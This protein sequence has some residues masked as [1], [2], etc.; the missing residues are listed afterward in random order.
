MAIGLQWHQ[1]VF[2]RAIY[3]SFG[4]TAVGNYLSAYTNASIIFSPVVAW[5]GSGVLLVL[6]F[7]AEIILRRHPLHWKSAEGR[8]TKIDRLHTKEHAALLGAF[9]LLWLPQVL[10]H[11]GDN[12]DLP[13]WRLVKQAHMLRDRADRFVNVSAIPRM[14]PRNAFPSI[15]VLILRLSEAKKAI[16]LLRGLQYYSKEEGNSHVGIDLPVLSKEMSDTEKQMSM[17]KQQLTTIGTSLANN[18]PSPTMVAS[19]GSEVDK[20][21]SQLAYVD[22]Q[23]LLSELSLTSLLSSYRDRFLVRHQVYPLSLY[24][25]VSLHNPRD[26]S[27]FMIGRRFT[28]AGTSFPTSNP[29]VTGGLKS[30]IDVSAVTFSV[31]SVIDAGIAGLRVTLKNAA[32]LRTGTYKADLLFDVEK[33]RIFPAVDRMRPLASLFSAPT[34]EMERLSVPIVIHVHE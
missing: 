32:S 30:L 5:T 3:A 7:S 29:T 12:G 33:K 18:D 10:V 22:K 21:S 15:P 1:K 26:V 8:R 9:L 28:P 19:I 2:S 14:A 27:R 24:Y 4:V 31:S 25:E 23:L 11:F 17:S 6:W 34:Y 16:D 13:D 20:L